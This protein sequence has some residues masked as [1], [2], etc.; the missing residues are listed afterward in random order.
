VEALGALAR[1]LK[2]P[3]GLVHPVTIRENSFRQGSR[4]PLLAVVAD[5]LV[6]LI[7]KIADGDTLTLLTPEKEQVR[8]R[9]AEIDAPECGQPWGRKAQDALI[10]EVAGKNAWN[11]Y[12]ASG[13][14]IEASLLAEL[15]SLNQSFVADNP[16][17]TPSL[18]Q[19]N[20]WQVR[21]QPLPAPG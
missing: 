15:F 10:D 12:R 8:V 4:V 9:L 5:G 11:S 13:I 3:M 21:P 14:G 18:T 19:F 16:T 17:C 7:V 1:R 6:G 2:V 20:W